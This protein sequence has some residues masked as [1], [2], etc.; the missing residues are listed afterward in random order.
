MVADHAE[1]L[2]VLPQL[3]AGM[4]FI[5]FTLPGNTLGFVVAGIVN[6]WEAS[7]AV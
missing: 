6:G 5:D 7:E 1:N 3:A 4:R 2:G